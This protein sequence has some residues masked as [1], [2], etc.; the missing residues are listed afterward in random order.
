MIRQLRLAAA[1][2][3]PALAGAI[4]G[5]LPGSVALFA[6]INAINDNDNDATL[7]PFWQVLAVVLATMLVVA[8]LTAAPARLGSRRPVTQ[9]LQAELA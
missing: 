8:V 1:Q 5:A 2:V 7:P 6:V 3:L 4:L 9:T